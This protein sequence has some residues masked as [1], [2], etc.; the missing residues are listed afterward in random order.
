MFKLFKDIIFGYRL[1]CAI[2]KADKFRHITHRKH[3]VIVIKGKPEVLS[4]QEVKMFL[5]HGIFNKGITMRDIEKKA[6][7]ITM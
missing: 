5:S 3:M 4:K 2:K 1:K 7:Y 6:L